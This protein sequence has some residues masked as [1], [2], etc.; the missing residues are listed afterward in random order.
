VNLVLFEPAEVERPLPRSDAR[1]RHILKVLR[2]PPGERFDVGLVNGPRG[3]AWIVEDDENQLVLSFEWA[4]AHAPPPPVHLAVGFPRPQTARDILR[5]ATT[6]GVT[7]LS[8]VTTARS[9]PNYAGS[10]LWTSTEWRRHILTGA[11]QAFDTWVPEVD[12]SHD[13]AQTVAAWTAPDMPLVV[14]DVYG[15]HP[16]LAA[17]EPAS[18]ISPC[19]LFIGPERGWDERDREVLH[20]ANASF[21][22]LGERVLRTEN[23]V[24]AVLALLNAARARAGKSPR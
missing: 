7:T 19:A 2:C 18:P 12:W 21:Y 24:T 17:Y 15:R 11:A 22:S 13:L 20:A 16:H 23:A 14:L 8:F 5:D 3:K 6:F 10:S 4:E 1:A 9:D